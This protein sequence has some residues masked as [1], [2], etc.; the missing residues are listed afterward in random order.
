MKKTTHK[1]VAAAMLL[2]VATMATG[3]GLTEN[4]TSETSQSEQAQNSTFDPPVHSL[5]KTDS[6]AI[7]M[8]VASE[9]MDTEQVADLKEIV[10]FI[11]EQDSLGREPDLVELYGDKPGLAVT[12][13]KRDEYAVDYIETTNGAG[14]QF[15]SENPE[16]VAA[17]HE[18]VDNGEVPSFGSGDLGVYAPSY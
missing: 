18:W 2:S 9:N 15:S 4:E 7:H 8:I 13:E 16:I 10:K 3:C 14:L 6:G 5:E 17:L 12:Q 11:S 1:I